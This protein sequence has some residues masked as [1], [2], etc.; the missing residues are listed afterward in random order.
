M[1]RLGAGTDPEAMQRSNNHA[2]GATGVS[3]PP[4][5]KEQDN[6][7]IAKVVVHRSLHANP[8]GRGSTPQLT[9]IGGRV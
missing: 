5:C 3:M 2:A 4:E 7:A 9:C 6:L 1:T 8:V